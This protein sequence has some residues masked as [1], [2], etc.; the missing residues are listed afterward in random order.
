MSWLLHAFWLNCVFLLQEIQARA[1]MIHINLV[2]K[3]KKIFNA[4]N[5]H[6][7]LNHSNNTWRPFKALVMTTHLIYPHF[8]G[9]CS[10]S[11]SILLTSFQC[12]LFFFP[13]PINLLLGVY[14]ER[15]LLKRVQSRHDQHRHCLIVCSGYNRTQS[16]P[17]LA[18]VP[19]LGSFNDFHP[20]RVDASPA[21][22]HTS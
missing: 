1:H 13:H 2:Q 6:K 8:H 16:E 21:L 5:M 17:L 4:P 14:S 12:L 22:V 3:K 11:C 9:H 15:P 20:Q 7:N 18:H 19:H 10:L